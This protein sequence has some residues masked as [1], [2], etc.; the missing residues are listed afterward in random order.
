MTF[1]DLDRA[2]TVIGWL[3]EQMDIIHNTRLAGFR[4]M[5]FD[6]RI[7]GSNGSG[8]PVRT[9]TKL[10]R[11]LLVLHLFNSMQQIYL[12][13]ANIGSATEKYSPPFY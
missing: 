7:R 4:S 6:W 9:E 5:K 1:H 12:L 11:L 8:G 3:V 10:N 13:K 2:A